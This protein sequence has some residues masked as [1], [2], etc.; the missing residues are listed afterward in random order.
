MSR[1]FLP[2]IL[3]LLALTCPAFG[4]PQTILYEH[5]TAVW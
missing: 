2:V 4:A 1:P 5:F 3:I